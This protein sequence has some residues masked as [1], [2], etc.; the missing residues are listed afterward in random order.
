MAR[1]DISLTYYEYTTLAAL[2]ICQQEVP[3]VVILEVGLG[4]RLDATN[5]ID[6]DIAVITSIDLDHQAFLGD[7][8]ELIGFEKKYHKLVQCY[9]FCLR[10][11]LS[12]YDIKFHL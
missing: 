3:D 7:T 8:K 10:T 9:I 11:F 5:I 6:A 2:M 1:G 4:G 12:F